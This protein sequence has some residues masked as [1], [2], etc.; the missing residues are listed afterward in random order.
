MAVSKRTRYEVLR[1]DAFTCRYCRS[2]DNTITVDHVV[3]VALGGTDAPDNLVAACRDCNA[4]KA[5]SSPN[6]ATV[7]Q[8]TDD[9]VRWASAMRQAARKRAKSR[10]AAEAYVD[11]F[12]TAWRR[13]SWG[14]DNHEVPRPADWPLSIETFY[15]AG[16]PLDELI[17]CVLI[18]CSKQSVTAD[19]IWRYMCGIAWNKLSEIQVD[20]AAIFGRGGV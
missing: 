5:A 17:D 10:R 13:W 11:K 14:P 2:A 16:L 15:T 19:R 1:R 8:V 9:A 7:A 6:E 3:P 12:D 20:A 4:G 18:A